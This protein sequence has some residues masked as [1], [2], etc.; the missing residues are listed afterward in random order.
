MD[1]MKN[2]K[3]E[4]SHAQSLLAK[5]R[6]LTDEAITFA[7][8]PDEIQKAVHNLAGA[9]QCQNVALDSL[10]SAIARLCRTVE[11]L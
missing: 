4:L 1:G 2:I 7:R 6:T 5:A 10:F 11:K 9:T 3:D 8:N